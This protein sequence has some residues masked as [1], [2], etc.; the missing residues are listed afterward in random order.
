MDWITLILATLTAVAGNLSLK[1]GMSVLGK[2]DFSKETLAATSSNIFSQPFI[3]GGLIIYALSMFLWLKV[4]STTQISKAYP[5]LVGLSFVLVVLG[6]YFFFK[7]ELSFLKI[8]GILVIFFGVLI[9][10][11]G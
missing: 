9:I 3:I 2:I 10:A 1:K 4:L 11:R 8:L 5:I 6:S 7:E